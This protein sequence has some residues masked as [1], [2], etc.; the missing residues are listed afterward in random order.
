MWYWLGG[1]VVMDVFLQS[2]AI[3]TVYAEKPNLM[4]LF[5]CMCVM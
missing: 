4:G 1:V 5:A 2:V 3:P